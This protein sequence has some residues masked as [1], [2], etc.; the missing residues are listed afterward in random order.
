MPPGLVEAD[1]KGCTVVGRATEGGL[2]IEVGSGERTISLS[3]VG[4][5][6]NAA[7]Y[8]RQSGAI[9]DEAL[10]VARGLAQGAG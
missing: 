9:L 7:E 4:W 6:V 10:D 8:G 2:R 1:G 5:V 3:D